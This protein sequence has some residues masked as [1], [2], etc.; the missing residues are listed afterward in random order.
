VV[1]QQLRTVSRSSVAWWPDSGATT[2]TVGWSFILASTQVVR[3]ALEAAAAEGLVQRHLFLHGHGHAVDLDRADVE[4]GL[5]VVL[6]Q[7]VHQVQAG[8]QRCD[9]GVWRTATAGG[10][11]AWPMRWRI[12]KRASRARWV[13]KS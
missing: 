4:L 12:R 3:E 13:S 10:C 9:R 2:S 11:R 7:A 6:G 8:R 1:L 5:F